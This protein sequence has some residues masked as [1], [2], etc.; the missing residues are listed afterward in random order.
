MAAPYHDRV[1][2]TAHWTYANKTGIDAFNSKKTLL[3]MFAGGWDSTH[4]LL[5]MAACVLL[6]YC[7]CTA[8][9]LLVY[10]QACGAL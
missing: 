5:C 4:A 3:L 6:L 10:C 7:F 9:V 1:A 2:D 8:S